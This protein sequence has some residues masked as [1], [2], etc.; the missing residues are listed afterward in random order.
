M[1]KRLIIACGLLAALPF[2]ASASKLISC[3]T[4]DP[5]P[6]VLTS[7]DGAGALD[8]T[9]DS[10]DPN[11]QVFEYENDTDAVIN[12]LEFDATILSGL[13]PGFSGTTIV[14]TAADTGGD[15]T[16]GPTTPADNPIFQNFNCEVVDSGV[17]PGF[18]QSCTVSYNNTTGD[19]SYLFAGTGPPNPPNFNINFGDWQGEEAGIPSC[20]PGDAPSVC[21][22]PPGGMGPGDPGGADYDRGLFKLEFEGFQ[23][24]TPASQDYTNPN[25]PP[26]INGSYTTVPEPSFVPLIGLGLAGLWFVRRRKF[27]Q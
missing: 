25:S 27:A 19:L 2:A 7:L 20:P 17:D 26:G 15:I 3:S 1:T 22:D 10:T 18:F 14:Y 11:P 5:T 13:T 8:V 23:A 9:L 4:C 21:D 6:V 12:S 24:G 16:S